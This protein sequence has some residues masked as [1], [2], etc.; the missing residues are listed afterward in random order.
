MVALTCNGTHLQL[1]SLGNDL[2]KGI[3]STSLMAPTPSGA[4]RLLPKNLV[5]LYQ[6]EDGLQVLRGCFLH[7][8][9]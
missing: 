5:L 7:L 6:E 4:V 2:A 8:Q 1:H 3:I 9:C